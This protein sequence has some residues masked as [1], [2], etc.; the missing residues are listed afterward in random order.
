MLE[1]AGKEREAYLA[2]L[3]E[4]RIRKEL[5]SDERSFLDSAMARALALAPRLPEF[6]EDTPDLERRELP[7]RR[8]LG[9]EP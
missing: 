8:D 2:R 9:Q 4:V 7:P 6:E 5:G 3:E 1:A